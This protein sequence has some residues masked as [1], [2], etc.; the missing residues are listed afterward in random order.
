M[1]VVPV[2]RDTASEGVGATSTRVVVVGAGPAGL[3]VAAC[4][5]R[6]G[7]GGVVLERGTAVGGSWRERYDRLHLHTPR[8]QSGLPGL[9]IPRK[10][11]RWVARDDV[12]AYLE[13]YAAHHR[14]R[15]WFG[16]DVER[17]DRRPEGWRVSTSAGVLDASDVVLAT[18][19]NAVPWLPDWG[20]PASYL[21]TV[22]HA[23]AYRDG[24]RYAGQDVLVVGSGNTGA[25]IAVD[26]V[27][28]GAARVRVSIRT[29]PHVVPRT[30]AGVPTTLLGIANQF[31]PA[32]VGDPINTALQRATIG[33]LS[34]AGLPAP[35]HGLVRNFRERDVVPIID[36]GF[37]DLLRAGRI[38]VVTG[39]ER[40]DQEGVALSDGSRLEP[41]AVIAATGYRTGLEPIVGHLGVLDARGRPTW[42]AGAQHPAAPGL[43]VVGLRNPLIGLLN[44]IGFDARRV[45][46]AIAGGRT[47]RRAR[48]RSPTRVR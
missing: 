26:L 24:S 25:E 8:I 23:A 30:V 1:T 42:R 39:V 38:E 18:G 45:A 16:V 6:L 7:V 40:L 3:A 10:A 47:D 14:I 36:V 33:D 19:Y 11:G 22:E 4:L 35:E 5:R 9:R 2:A 32:A 31:V 13:A 12:V 17:V 46:R 48:P 44:A 29:P 21:G 20:D 15:P 28:H 34:T 43:H 27:E 41:D 37:V